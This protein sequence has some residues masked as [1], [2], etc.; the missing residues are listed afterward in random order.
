MLPYAGSQ[1]AGAA[2]AS[3]LLAICLPAVGTLGMTS[4]QTGIASALL[5]EI[6]LTAML[7]LVILGLATGAKEKG[8]TAGI[9]IGG[10]VALAALFG[11]PVSGASMNPAPS[12][13]PAVIS[14]DPANLWIY[15]LAPSLGAGLAVLACRCVGRPGCSAMVRVGTQAAMQDADLVPASRI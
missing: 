1:C 5:F 7:M 15:W 2:L 6:L 3:G 10:T 9:A 8:L 14:G 4:P 13:G 11:G 12:L